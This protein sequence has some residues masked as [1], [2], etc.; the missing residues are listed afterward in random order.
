MKKVAVV[1][2]GV[3]GL[4][5]SYFLVKKGCAVT[6][7]EKLPC[8]GGK[9]QTY[10]TPYGIV[11]SAANA[12]LA[13]ALV[14]S[15]CADIGVPLIGT[16]KSSKARYIFSRGKPRRWPL[17]WRDT[18]ALITFYFKKPWRMQADLKNK[19]LEKWLQQFVSQVVIDRVFTPACQGT[20]GVG[21]E[22]LSASLVMNYFFNKRKMPKGKLKGSVSAPEGMGQIIA[23]LREHL[24]T[25][26]VRF[27]QAE[28]MDVKDVLTQFDEVIIATDITAAAQLLSHIKDHRGQVLAAV[29]TV[30]L[31]S[32]N[33]FWGNLHAAYPGFGILFPR[34]EG[35][36]ALG[37]L[38]NSFIFEGRSHQSLSETWIYRK[39]DLHMN[40]LDTV[41]R[42]RHQVLG[43]GQELKASRVNEWPKALPLYGLELE[44]TLDNFP[45]GHPRVHLMGNYL[46]EIGLNRLFARAKQLAEDL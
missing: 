27:E 19:T 14:E 1:G 8:A 10:K 21:C 4:L 41:I 35:I 42:D 18:L 15:V 28:V 32:I 24:V 46:G 44:R 11:E 30:D 40:P 25:Q 36:T 12:V 7:L 37:V 6:V 34:G 22:R 31:V 13:D 17:G 38:Q 39:E 33:V 43:D 20:F 16:R 29:P 23:G 2:A 3:S 45:P 9:I 5:A 26:G